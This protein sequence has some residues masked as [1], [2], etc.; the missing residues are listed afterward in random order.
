MELSIAKIKRVI[1][2]L[3]QAA[4]LARNQLINHLKPFGYSPSIHVPNIWKH[5]T[6]PT[7]FCL[8]VDDFGVILFQ[9]RMRIILFITQ[10]SLSNNNRQAR[11]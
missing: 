2:G 5:N 3:K 11:F 9:K 7:K 1:N 8:C 4:R 6:Q 10:R